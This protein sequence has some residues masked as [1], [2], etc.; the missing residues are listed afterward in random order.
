M[1]PS[2]L[3]KEEGGANYRGALKTENM[4]ILKAIWLVGWSVSRSYNIVEVGK[5]ASMIL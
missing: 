2:G 1:S 4:V 3:K 5:C